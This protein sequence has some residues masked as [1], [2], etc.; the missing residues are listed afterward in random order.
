MMKKFLFL[1]SFLGVTT[2]FAYD[3]HD[4]DPASW[5]TDGDVRIPA[6]TTVTVDDDH[7]E[8]F[9]GW[10]N[11]YFENTT[12]KIVFANV[13]KT[14]Y[15]NASIAYGNGTISATDCPGLV[16]TGD[17]SKLSASG[18]WTFKNSSVIVSNE[19][20]LG[21][22]S[23]GATTVKFTAA[24]T[25]GSLQFGLPNGQAFTNHTQ[26]VYDGENGCT[27]MSIGSASPDEKFVQDGNFF[28]IPNSTNK[29]LYFKNNY[30]QISGYFGYRAAVSAPLYTYGTTGCKVTIGGSTKVIVGTNDPASTPGNW[31]LMSGGEYHFANVEGGFHLDQISW[32]SGCD[33]HFDVDDVFKTFYTTGGLATGLNAY[34]PFAVQHNA[35]YWNKFNLHGHDLSF[36]HFSAGTVPPASGNYYYFDND[37]DAATVTLVGDSSGSTYFGTWGAPVEFRGKTSFT[38]DNK[39]HNKIS[40]RVSTT[41]GA[42]TVKAGSTL[43]YVTDGGWAGTNAVVEGGATL[44][45]NSAK[46]FENGVT[47]LV[48]ADG[49]KLSVSLATAKA[50]FKSVT[51][52]SRKLTLVPGTHRI[53]ALKADPELAPFFDGVDSAAVTIPVPTVAETWPAGGTV[54]LTASRTCADADAEAISKVAKIVV[55][56]GG[57]LLFYQNKTPITVNA[58]IEG[59]GEVKA[60]QCTAPVTFAGDNRHR[61]GPLNIEDSDVIV[62]NDYGLG[63]PGSPSALITVY[64]NHTRGKLSFVPA[65]GRDVITNH[66]GLVYSIPEVVNGVHSETYPPIVLGSTATDTYFVQDG[67]LLLESPTNKRFIYFTNNYEQVSGTF[68]CKTFQAAIYIYPKGVT[69]DTKVTFSGTTRIRNGL[70]VAPYTTSDIFIY[71][72]TYRFGNSGG[73]NFQALTVHIP[74]FVHFDIDDAFHPYLDPVETG[75]AYGVY[76]L[77]PYTADQVQYKNSFD[78]HGHDL[79]VCALLDRSPGNASKY[80][81]LRTEDDRPCTVSLI[82]DK[83]GSTFA[84][85]CEFQGPVSLVVDNGAVN[86]FTSRVSRTEGSL[87]VKTGTASFSSAGGWSGTNAVVKAGATLS[88]ATESV[89]KMFVDELGDP[90]AAIALEQDSMLAL[91]DGITKV[92]TLTVNGELYYRGTYGGS[93]SSAARKIANLAG[94]GR[95]KVTEGPA[96]GL[97][98]IVR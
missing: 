41:E 35:T 54:Y 12:S 94:R 81:Y 47:D 92:R 57:R 61:K 91:A 98:I 88:A 96:Y 26:I 6:S 32:H 56:P 63:G 95:L 30:E 27:T 18:T 59:P 48:I 60:Y 10:K 71:G 65:D 8:A 82:G 24:G 28:V 42:L 21:S 70:D 85:S 51:L 74:T 75:R 40:T 25:L 20:G 80:F 50:C 90:R 1:A 49:G 66:C 89:P 19:F 29:K 22:A 72:G 33:V 13:S 64:S 17:N 77:E 5:P 44:I 93:D 67:D 23:S 62:A 83:A 55:C 43:E 86:A 14:A 87:V 34:A 84:S 46:A 68:G 39:A 4:F 58:A 2:G 16:I 9:A 38:V 15:F 31:F 69:A 79:K 52:G 45:A 11:I 97:S 37:G 53:S 76:A 3:W 36:N 7:V 73:A 78:L